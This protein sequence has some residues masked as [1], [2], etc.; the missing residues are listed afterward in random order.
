MPHYTSWN[1]ILI[2]T[3]I[4]LKFDELKHRVIVGDGDPTFFI[5][6]NK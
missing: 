5:L 2:K 6:D 1:Q 3:F 4:I